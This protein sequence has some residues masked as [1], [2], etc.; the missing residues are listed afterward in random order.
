MQQEI[1]CIAPIEFELIKRRSAVYTRVSTNKEDQQNS[2]AAQYIHYHKMLEESETDTLVEVYADEG[3]TGTS[4]KK[5]DNFNRMIEDCR[6]GK[7]DRIYCKSVSRFGRNT[8]ECIKIV[9]ELKALG[10]TVYFEKENLDTGIEENEFRLTMMEFQAQ[11]ESIS[12]S[13]NVRIGERYRMENGDYI[14]KTAPYGYDRFERTIVVNEAE[15]VIVRRIFYDYTHGKSIRQIVRELN[16]EGV[17]RK[18]P[19]EKWKVNIVT[20][21]L[22]NE[23]YIGDQMYLKR[24]RTETFPFE[25][26]RNHGEHEYYYIEE[27]HEPIIDRETFEYAQQL[28]KSRV[29]KCVTE[30]SES[31]PLSGRIHCANCGKVF[32][33][34]NN[35]TGR[36]WACRTHQKDAKSCPTMPI[37]DSEITRAFIDMYN[38]LKLNKKV[39]IQPIITQLVTLKNSIASNSVD[40]ANLDQRMML[41]N[42]Q[43]AILTKLK[44]DKLMDEET[45]RRKSNELNNSLNS[46]RSQRRLF[47]NNSDADK[48]IAEI[49]KLSAILDKGP[50]KL[51]EFDEDLF[52]ELIEDIT[53]DTTETI[54]FKIVGGLVL[55]EQIERVKR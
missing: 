40:Y 5:R 47:L 28:R 49:K 46:L 13:K 26:I 37:P 52:N 39:I 15:A 30:E 50:S 16:A 33:I 44:K 41:I 6:K 31:S 42:D 23:K 55:K 14:L 43:L 20:Y 51:S 45:F 32:R 34:K 9:R 7:I 11:E 17:P 38:K 18:N 53:A 27:S 12:I 54:R 29:P 35:P 36:I 22:S 4:T 8:A 3:I 1:T 25:R 19:G 2:F 24:Y 10:I 21:I 48:A